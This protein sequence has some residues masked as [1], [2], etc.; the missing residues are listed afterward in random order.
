MSTGINMRS[1]ILFFGP[2]DLDLD[3]RHYEEQDTDAE[4]SE[5][6]PY[7]SQGESGTS[8]EVL[9][10]QFSTMMKVVHEEGH[11][12]RH[13]ASTVGYWLN[14]VNA[15]RHCLSVSAL[16]N[17]PISFKGQAA[18]HRASGKPVIGSAWQDASSVFGRNEFEHAAL[19]ALR[20]AGSV[21]SRGA[22]LTDPVLALEYVDMAMEWVSGQFS[23]GGAQ[24]PGLVE[25]FQSLHALR[26]T[27][28]LGSTTTTAIG[29]AASTLDELQ[30]LSLGWRKAI[31]DELTAHIEKKFRGP[32]GQ[33]VRLIEGLLGRPAPISLCQVLFDYSLN[34]PVPGLDRRV[35]RIPWG[36]FYPPLRLERI[37]KGLG[38]A[39][40]DLSRTPSAAEVMEARECIEQRTGVIYGRVDHPSATLQTTLPWNAVPGAVELFHEMAVL[41][42]AARLQDF[43]DDTPQLVTNFATLAHVRGVEFFAPAHWKDYSP[44]IWSRLGDFIPSGQLDVGE[45][46]RLITSTVATCVLDD[47]MFGVGPLSVDHLPANFADGDEAREVQDKAEKNLGLGS[48]DRWLPH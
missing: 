3:G 40:P 6:N 26:D 9:T 35:K 45:M 33:P 14:Q 18:A 36:D 29:E 28:I 41:E 46:E 48:L 23:T 13:H 22:Y 37:V 10:R 27:Q 19:R 42:P 47:L 25:R 24:E 15:A 30:L 44:A 38:T 34:P 4:L 5:L 39:V 11:W 17:M 32:Y 31:G 21:V 8:P 16:R 1:C 7:M 43:G 2:E 20:Y 12:V